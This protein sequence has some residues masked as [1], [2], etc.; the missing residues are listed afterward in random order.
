MPAYSGTPDFPDYR[1]YWSSY[2]TYTDATSCLLHYEYERKIIDEFDKF[3]F[4][5]FGDPDNPRNST[6]EVWAGLRKAQAHQNLS[7]T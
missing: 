2:S 6:E 5:C 3:V 4:Y 7:M 1:L